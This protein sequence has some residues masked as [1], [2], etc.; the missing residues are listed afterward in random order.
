MSKTFDAIL[1]DLDG[2][3]LPM[4]LDAFTNHYFNLVA[5]H[6]GRLGIQPEPVLRAVM[7]G[8]Q[9]M[10]QNDGTRSNAQRFRDC[11]AQQMGTRAPALI[12]AFDGFY[13]DAFHQA[14]T[15]TQSNP[16]AVA[17]VAA[18]RQKASRVVLATNPLFPAAGIQARLSW[19]GLHLSDF[20]CVTTYE[21]A[22]FCKPNPA[23]YT[24]IIQSLNL[25][26]KHLL[27]IGNDI[28]EDAEAA[29]AAGLA[30]YLVTDCLIDHGM[31][32]DIYQHGSFRQMLDML[33][34]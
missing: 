24:Q 20:D 16:D 31:C 10:I 17:A 1:F 4:D 27:M 2:T 29:Q 19:I 5:E 13:N 9:S 14:R 8:T 23:Y 30:T 18:A 21:N 28:R 26:G 25:T 11:F 32:A 34:K 7:L 6:F 22:S 12:R 3:L 15:S 33:G